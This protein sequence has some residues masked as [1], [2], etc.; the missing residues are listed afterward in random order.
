MGKICN[1]CL[2]CILEFL[3]VTKVYLKC[4]L[5]FSG[6]NFWFLYWWTLIY[7]LI[8]QQDLFSPTK[9][10]TGMSKFHQ[11]LYSSLIAYFNHAP[12]FQVDICSLSQVI[13]KNNSLSHRH[14]FFGNF[15]GQGGPILIILVL[16][17]LAFGNNIFIWN[18]VGKLWTVSP[19]ESKK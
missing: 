13:R 8:F 5:S 4:L 6:H 12:K 16:L 3:R 1:A 18:A 11:K 2:S 9:I 14:Q 19:L 17:D 7:G 15:S 10:C